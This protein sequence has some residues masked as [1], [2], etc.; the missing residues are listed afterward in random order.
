MACKESVMRNLLWCG[1]LVAGLGVWGWRCAIGAG[2]VSRPAAEAPARS[3]P[4]LIQERIDQQIDLLKAESLEESLKMLSEIDMFKWPGNRADRSGGITM[5]LKPDVGREDIEEI[6]SNRR[7]LKVMDELG[8]LPKGKAAALVTKEIQATLPVYQ[9][10]LDEALERLVNGRAAAPAGIRT[11]SGLSMQVSN[12]QDHSP[13]LAGARLK[14]LA[15]V[16]AAGNLDLAEARGAVRE[17]ATFACQQRDQLYQ[18]H[19]LLTEADRFLILR[20]A[21]LYNRQILVCGIQQRSGIKDWEE[22]KLTK[23]DAQTTSYDGRAG[24]SGRVDYAKGEINV[25]FPRPI[26]DQALDE[27]M[28]GQETR[29]RSGL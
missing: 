11:S 19:A 13:T 23:F 29:V 9:K 28:K 22:K 20:Q 5:P 1:I 27:L 14:L 16:L 17:V 7:F 2:A 3:G 18:P 6:M 12:N 15:L 25:A 10:M 24:A 26:A 8:A 4:A 21:T